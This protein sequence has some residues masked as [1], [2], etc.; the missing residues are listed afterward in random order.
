MHHPCLFVLYQQYKLSVSVQQPGSD[1]LTRSVVGP[2][3]KIFADRDQSSI[4]SALIFAIDTAL[5]ENAEF[6]RLK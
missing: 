6:F 1:A 5:E 3:H 4:K 2:P